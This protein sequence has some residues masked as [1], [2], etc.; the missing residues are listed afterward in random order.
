MTYHLPLIRQLASVRAPDGGV[1]DSLMAIT[2]QDNKETV[3]RVIELMSAGR[4]D[5]IDEY[6]AEDVVF[7]GPGE[8]P[9]E[10]LD[11]FKDRCLVFDHAF[12]DWS[13]EIHDQIAEDDKVVTR[14]TN[15]ATHE[16][17]LEGIEPTGNTVELTGIMIHR[18]EDGKVV[19]MIQEADN[20]DLLGQIGVMGGP[21][22]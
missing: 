11:A 6:I 13:M 7:H 4:L 18:F 3:R 15:R 20:A 9:G 8:P 12:P 22:A 2:T 1:G 21:E 14:F 17:E 19:E 10:G 16:G 5:E